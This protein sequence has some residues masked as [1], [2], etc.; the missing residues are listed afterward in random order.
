MLVLG[1]CDMRFG[2]SQ[3]NWFTAFVKTGEEDNV[4]ERLLFRFTGSNV[5][6]LVPKRRLRERKNGTWEYKIRT[7]FPGY[8]LIN[9]AIGVD[10][11]YT[12][13]DV[14][15]LIKVLK[16][17]SGLLQIEQPEISVISR[18][19]CN[20]EII[21]S[22]SIY[23][24]GSRVVVIDGPLLGLDGLIDSIDKRKGRVKIRLNFIGE[25]RLV[26]LSVSMVQPA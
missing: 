21:G 26:D 18:L 12:M 7:L 17:K 23:M 20:N 16:D 25:T 1:E 4:K 15:G 24:Q 11:Y 13:K 14:P 9:G 19:I 10:E 3:D 6:F 2:D 22:S 5:K 8:V